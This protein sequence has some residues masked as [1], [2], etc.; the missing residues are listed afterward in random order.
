MKKNRLE[1][2]TGQHKL[3]SILLIFIVPFAVV[4]YQ[5]IGEIDVKIEFAQKERQGIK[6][7]F[8][9]RNLLEHVIDHRRITNEYLIENTALKEEIVTLQSQIE[10]D[11]KSVDAVERQLGDNLKTTQQWLAFKQKWQ[12]LKGKTLSLSEKESFDAHIAQID[13]LLSLM[14]H[15]GDTSNLITDPVLESYYLMDALVTKLPPAIEKTARARDS[16]AEMAVDKRINADEKA[17]IT[18][19]SNSIKSP[20]EAVHR[21]MQVAFGANPKLKPKL[22]TYNQ[23][24]F[25]ATNSFLELINKRM[26]SDQSI[27]IQ[28]ADYFAAG[29][30]AIQTQFRLY[31]G[32]SPAL[33]GL[34]EERINGFS[35]KKILVLTFSLLVLATLIYVLV[36]FARSLT[37]RQQSE[38]ALREAEEKYR[39]IF[40]NAVDGIFQTTPDGHYLSANPALARIY[41]YESP[42]ELI[43]NLTSIGQQLYVD[44]NRREEFRRSIQNYDTVSDFESQVYRKDGSRIWISENARAVHDDNGGLL[45][46][47]GTVQDITRRKHAEEERQRAEAELQKAII[48]AETANRAKS[49]FLANMSHELRTP[50]NAI[51]GYS[52][53]LQEEAEELGQEDFIPDYQKIHAAGKHLLGLINDILD[54]SKI[55]AGRMELYLE[56]FD[57]TAVVGDVVTTIQPLVEKNANKL[58]VECA[59]NIGLM[60]ADLTKV[61]QTLFNLLS[62]ACKFTHEGTIA[63]TVSRQRGCKAREAGEEVQQ[64]ENSSPASVH[65]PLT[66]QD[67]ITFRVSDTGIGMTPEQMSKLFEAFTQADASTTRQYGGTGLGLAITKKLCQ[68]MGGDVTVS[69]EIGKG[70]TFTISIP[71]K[72]IDPKTQPTQHLPLKSNPLP[73]G[74]RTVL[75]IDDDPTVHDLMQRFLVREG[76]RVESVL[77][78]EEGLRLAKELQPDAITLDVMMP[79]MDG[80]A[81]LSGLKADP[82]LADIPVI[83]LTIVDNKTMGYAL[84]ASDYL[85]KPIDRDRLSAILKKYQSNR[86]SCSLLLVDDDAENREM[87]R[88]ILQKEG[89]IVT[90][91]ENGRIGL[92]RIAENQP[93][94]ILLDLM[95]PEMDGFAFV[96]ELQQH[97]S[98]RSIP[99]VVLTAKDI[100]PEDRQCL[101]GYVENILQK[102]AY[103]CDELLAQVR[104]LVS[105]C[106]A[107]KAQS[108]K[109][110]K[111]KG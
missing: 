17:Q 8:A 99:V 70:S 16:K 81:V 41:G 69:S 77:S 60:H 15:V 32:A 73:V 109:S 74:A 93:E 107:G 88:R 47:E 86:S 6:Y 1:Q 39:Q 48:T 83:M 94:L 50:L 12:A 36:A 90:E 76:F 13:A 91:A 31:D 62:N 108:L 102:G 42:E 57:V 96:N 22:E 87:I 5:L 72:V 34:L 14:L 23:E 29:T 79:S 33:D 30:K 67:W 10:A 52:E 98:W 65:L 54:L 80:W 111:C 51:I 53:M 20:N 92:E 35:R 38:K 66:T 105:S 45:Y 37:K 55:E 101:N 63:L 25:I 78:G 68:M 21:G 85:T 7:N 26:M 2:L 24:S 3:V 27:A 49:Q 43:A 58:N 71:A 28:Q 89:W 106:V 75:V 40:E 97:E 64:R 11:I 46:Y 110:M 9:L 84:G 4:V 61:R 56:T 95:M 59:D 100:T 18:I 103:T 19:L 104:N 44:P 82:E